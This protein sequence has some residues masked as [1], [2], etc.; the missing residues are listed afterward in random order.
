MVEGTAYYPV[1][2][3]LVIA[4]RVRAGSIQG[5][6]RDDLAPSRRYY[7]GGGGSVRGYGFQRLGP[8]EPVDPADPDARRNPVGGRS[9]NEFA[10]EA[11]YRF[12]NFG[13]V[14]FI[15]AGNSYEDS[16]PTFSALRWGAGIG[17]RFYT[18]FGP[19]RVDVATPLNPRPGDGKVALYISIG[20]AF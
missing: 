5:I 4:G 7:G 11:R 16:L 9:L 3:S 10:V 20:Q 6:D 2:D 13:I 15:D 17:G 19:F 18:N 14:P 8:F 12:G 1:N